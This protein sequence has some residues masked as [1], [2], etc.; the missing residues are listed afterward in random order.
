MSHHDLT[1]AL[2]LSTAR[3][4]LAEAE[5]AAVDD[6]W[7]T[8]AT[9]AYQAEVAAHAARMAARALAR[10]IP[11]PARAPVAADEPVPPPGPVR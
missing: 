8:A 11:A 9:K 10:T 4:R 3:T 2:S 6:D 5:E 7:S 1:F